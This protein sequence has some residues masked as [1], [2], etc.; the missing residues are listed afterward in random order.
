M[1]GKAAHQQRSM[2]SRR[3]RIPL[4]VTYIVVVVLDRCATVDSCYVM[5]IIHEPAPPFALRTPLWGRSAKGP[6]GRW[7]ADSSTAC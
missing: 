4:V 2:Q 3:F 1:D 6:T 5:Y 7:K